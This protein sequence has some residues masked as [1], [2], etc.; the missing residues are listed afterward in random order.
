MHYII[1]INNNNSTIA[2]AAP[3]KY[4]VAVVG[5]GPSGAC[6][7]EILAQ[8]PK[9]ETI[10]FE[11][12]MDNCKPCGGAIPVCMVDEFNVSFINILFIFIY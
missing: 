11:R 3:G 9:I 10:M 12:K 8:N 1:L 6:A 4:K 7:A 2:L 5:G